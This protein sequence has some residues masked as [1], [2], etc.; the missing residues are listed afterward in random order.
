MRSI[1]LFPKSWNTPISSTRRNPAFSSASA[2]EADLGTRCGVTTVSSPS[3][4]TA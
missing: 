2:H 1:A 3:C 4:S